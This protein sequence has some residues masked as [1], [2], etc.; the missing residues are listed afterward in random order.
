MATSATVVRAAEVTAELARL[1][2]RERAITRRRRELLAQIDRLYLAAPLDAA[3]VDWL[4]RLEVS[5][6]KISAQRRR[7]HAE[8]DEV[9]ARIGLGPWREY[10]ELDSAA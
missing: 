8:I 7:L 1:D 4:E 9:H 5:E 10:R 3:H 6:R 2:V